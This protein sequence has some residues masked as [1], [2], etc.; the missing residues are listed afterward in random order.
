ME[1]PK[2]TR[3][4]TMAEDTRDLTPENPVKRM[5]YE[6]D[7]ILKRYESG[8]LTG[9]DIARL[10]IDRIM[11][12]RQTVQQYE[13]AA[14]RDWNIILTDST[15]RRLY[16]VDNVEADMDDEFRAKLY[17]FYDSFSPTL[18]T[19]Y[20]TSSSYGY[21]QDVLK[22]AAQDFFQTEPVTDTTPMEDELG[23]TPKQYEYVNHPSH[24]NNYSLEVIDMFI[25][26]YGP[27]NTA[28]FC[29]MNALK[30]RMRVGEK[31]D[32]P[33]EQDLD[34]EKWYLNKAKQIRK[35]YNL[36]T[37]DFTGPHLST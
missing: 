4:L 6:M 31:P 37:P 24:Y 15:L 17:E 14:N 35:E 18:R 16:N 27:Q 9:Q 25:R 10:N 2:P 29:E 3:D 20:L 8:D 13:S 30:Y 26:I 33:I 7:G 34:K 1:K 21:I 28:T 32:N 5:N 11:E 23:Q 19:V 22:H 12:L 36:P